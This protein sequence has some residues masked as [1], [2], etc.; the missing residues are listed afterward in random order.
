[1]DRRQVARLRVERQRV[2]AVDAYV[3]P[4]DEVGLICVVVPDGAGQPTEPGVQMDRRGRVWLPAAYAWGKTPT[5]VARDLSFDFWH[6]STI[7]GLLNADGTWVRFLVEGPG[8]VVATGLSVR[9]L[10]A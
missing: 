3:P 8:R 4:Q 2:L 7:V 5:Q 6:P 1:M 10:E 9:H